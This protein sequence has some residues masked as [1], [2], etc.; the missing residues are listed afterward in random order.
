MPY[1]LSLDECAKIER[2]KTPRI[3]LSK[4][5]PIP[6]TSGRASKEEPGPLSRWPM[7]QQTPAAERIASEE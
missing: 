1:I 5:I 2:I 4:L 7:Q 6:C 3:Y